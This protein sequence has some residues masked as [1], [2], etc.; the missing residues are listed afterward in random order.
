MSGASQDVAEELLGRMAASPDVCLQRYDLAAN[1]ALLVDIGVSALREASF[2]DDRVLKPTMKAARVAV[3][4]MLRATQAISSLRP[5]HFIFHTGHVGSTLVSRLLDEMRTVLPLRE[6]FV[7]RQL[8]D[9]FDRLGHVDSLIGERDFEVLTVG[10]LRLWS[11]GD[12]STQAVVLKA[13]SSAGRIAPTLLAQSAGSRA[14][15]LNLRAEPYIAT[16]VAG[17]NAD[18]DLRGH[19]SERF[20]RL[21]SYGVDA[22]PPLYRHSKGELAAA[23]WLAET[24]SQHRTL[25]AHGDRILAVDF[26]ALLS[27]VAGHIGRIVKHL[28]LAHE[29]SFL[30]GIGESPVLTRYAK[31]PTHAYSPALRA[32]ILSDARKLHAQEIRKGLA[33]LDKLAAAN[34]SVAAVCA[35]AQL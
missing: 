28:S 3:G 22:L 20:R 25:D 18:T 9:T 17:Q 2:L 6:P 19:G 12:A 16:L 1:M 35:R 10:L 24:W 14:I 15:Y 34:P 4:R 29:P 33:W 13:T 8:A 11:R 26:D 27:D 5:L 30:A 21:V 23:S 32:Q 31:A 7:L